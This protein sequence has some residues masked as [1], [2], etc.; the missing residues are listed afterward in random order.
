MRIQLLLVTTAGLLVGCAPAP[1]F[2][3]PEQSGLVGGPAYPTA[4]DVCRVI[5]ENALTVDLL[6]DDSR[7]IG[8]PLPEAGAI[9]DRID[10][11]GSV[12]EV[13]GDW[14]LISVP[15]R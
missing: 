8:C 7:L 1:A 13:A 10:E 9:K 2:G 12:V 3:P 15:G 4:S 5:G 11:G 6:D 14:V